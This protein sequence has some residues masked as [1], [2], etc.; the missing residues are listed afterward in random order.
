[1]FLCPFFFFFFI[2]SFL[3]LS[4]EHSDALKAV[5]AADKPVV[6]G[7]RTSR[8][9]KFAA[10]LLSDV[11]VKT[12]LYL[13]KGACGMSKFPENNMKCYK[14]YELSDPVPEPSDEP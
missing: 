11:G 3:L 10:Q 2:D 6:I 14:S 13:D 9:A 5:L 4:G 12:A 7:C 1:M 8:R